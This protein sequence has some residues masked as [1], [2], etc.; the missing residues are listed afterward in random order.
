MGL[1]Y[2]KIN[3]FNFEKNV[4]G[5]NPYIALAHTSVWHSTYKYRI[6]GSQKDCMRDFI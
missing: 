2:P 6:K 4:T 5:S 1:K 3:L